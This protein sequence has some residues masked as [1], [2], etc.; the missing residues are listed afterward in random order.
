MQR[1][2]AMAR[3]VRMMNRQGTYPADGRI[4]EYQISD[5]MVCV[6]KKAGVYLGKFIRL[7]EKG[8][9]F[10]WCAALFTS[11][12]FAYRKMWKPAAIVMGINVVYSVAAAR[13]A[14]RFLYASFNQGMGTVAVT[15]FLFAVSMVVFGLLG[16]RLYWS[17]IS[18]ILDG[19]GCRGGRRASVNGQV[20]ETLKKAGGV[21]IAGVAGFW[22][23]S[24]VLQEVISW[25]TALIP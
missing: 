2:K 8:Y 12:W 9:S 11:L 6:G 24:I 7:Q 15:L 21:S 25:L 18:R 19:N 17:H 22:A 4:G 1:K 16:D 20:S 5:V 10:N 13:A 14:E 23:A 3:E